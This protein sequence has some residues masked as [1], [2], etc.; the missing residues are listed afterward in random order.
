MKIGIRNFLIKDLIS[1][2]RLLEENSS[3]VPTVPVPPF[4]FSV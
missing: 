4:T 2:M 1:R 3:C